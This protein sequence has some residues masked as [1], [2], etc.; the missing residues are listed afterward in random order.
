LTAQADKY[1]KDTGKIAVPNYTI[2]EKGKEFI[3]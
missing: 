3:K 1:W 2:T